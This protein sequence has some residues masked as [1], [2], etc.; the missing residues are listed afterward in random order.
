LPE[1]VL[2]GA[3]IGAHGIKGEV[4]VKTFTETPE[5]LNAYGALTTGDGRLLRIV[6]LRP[7]SGG[8]AVARFE[9]VDTREAAEGLKG[10]GLYVARA[11]LPEPEAGEFYQTDLIGLRVENR[12]GKHLGKV[13]ASHNFGAGDM[14]EIE[15]PDGETVFVPFTDDYIPLVDVEGGRIVAEL[16]RDEGNS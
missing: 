6:Q 14:I 12:E 8:G 15:A 1:R 9:G 16:P 2:L 13:V 5:S 4:K 3:V 11:T 10:Q 7:A